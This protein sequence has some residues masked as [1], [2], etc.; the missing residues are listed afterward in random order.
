M[1]PIH[2]HIKN[3][4]PPI[5]PNLNKPPLQHILDINFQNKQLQSPSWLFIN[6]LNDNP[7]KSID[8]LFEVETF[9]GEELRAEDGVDGGGFVG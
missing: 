4:P 6:Q 5:I 2:Q 3:E 7:S 8:K 1:L 9:V